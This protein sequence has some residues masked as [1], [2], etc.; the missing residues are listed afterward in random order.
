MARL[1]NGK[2][3]RCAR[4]ELGLCGCGVAPT[5]NYTTCANCRTKRS[6]RYRLQKAS[7]SCMRC[8]SPAI[9]GVFCESHAEESKLAIKARR[10]EL[11]REIF[12]SYGP[13][14]CCGE[15]TIEFL[16]ID[17]I[18][19]NG[20]KHRT[21]LK[22]DKLYRWLRD[23]GFPTDDYQSL[24]LNCNS[25]KGAFGCCPHTQIIAPKSRTA[26]RNRTRK[27]EIIKHYGGK[28]RCC[29]LK[30]LMFL[31]VNHD[32]GGGKKHRK[33]VGSGSS[34]YK[35]LKREGLPTGFSV[36]CWNCNFSHG[37]YGYCPHQGVSS[38]CTLIV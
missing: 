32:E 21:D 8:G 36:M 38:C 4:R 2:E 23:N 25:S 13:C 34:F 11:K 19:N 26:K 5:P 10:I 14:S 9:V 1:A 18:R 28:C 15:S 7:K 6:E 29:G 30:E 3:Y 24:C 27:E 17:H 20:A 33:E 31:T 22:A 37:L 35:W 16:T 12:D